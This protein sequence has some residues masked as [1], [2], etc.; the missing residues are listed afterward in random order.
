MVTVTAAD[1]NGTTI[2]RVVAADAAAEYRFRLPD[3]VLLKSL[4]SATGG[5]WTPAV[6]ALRAAPTDRHSERRPLWPALTISALGLW[7]IDL[8]LR[9]VRVLEPRVAPEVI[10]PLPA[11]AGRS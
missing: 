6:S 10:Y 1:A 8:L 3:A 9:R 4:A 5:S 11:T 2:S 7:F